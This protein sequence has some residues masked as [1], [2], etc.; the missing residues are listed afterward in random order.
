MIPHGIEL[1]AATDV[2]LLA[3]SG[4]GDSTFGVTVTFTDNSTQVFAGQTAAD[5]FSGT[6]NIALRYCS[7]TY[8]EKGERR[9]VME[10][11]RV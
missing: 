7:F 2:Y 5:W 4:N 9:K 3:T 6:T 1:R 8:R 10:S 11:V